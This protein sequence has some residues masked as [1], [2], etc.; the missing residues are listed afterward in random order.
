VGVVAA[1]FAAAVMENFD[2]ESAWLSITLLTA[3]YIL[4]RGFSKAGA[5]RGWEVD[6]R[7]VVEEPGAVVATPEVRPT[8][9]VEDAVAVS[10]DQEMPA[11]APEA[12]ERLEEVA[13]TPET[14]PFFLTSEFALWVLCTLGV[15][16]ASGVALGFGATAA[17]TF[18]TILSIG[19][20]L[21]RGISKAGVWRGYETGLGYGDAAVGPL[22]SGD[23]AT[24]GPPGYGDAATAGPAGTYPEFSTPE[25]KEFFRTSEFL[26]LVLVILGIM[27]ASNVDLGFNALHA[28]QLITAVA[29]AYMISRGI[30][31]MGTRQY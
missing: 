22:R 19:Y 18:V 16:I 21:S 3:G 10:H 1:L 26:V 4:S 30:A 7:P 9:P 28:W 8:V 27:L 20:I 13:R 31:K 23:A 17:W 24:T 14:K 6:D 25:T 11:T 5:S 15:L 29:V 2:A 12:R